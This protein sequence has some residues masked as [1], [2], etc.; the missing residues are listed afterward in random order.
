MSQTNFILIALVSCTLLFTAAHHFMLLSQKQIS[1]IAADDPQRK[2]SV[3]SFPDS[4]STKMIPIG[5]KLVQQKTSAF[6][7]EHHGTEY[8]GWTC[9]VSTFTSNTIVYDVGLGEDTSWDEGLIQKYNLQIFGFDPT[10]K[11]ALHVDQ[12]FPARTHFH[13]LKEGLSTRKET[14]TFTKPKNANHVSMRAG[15]VKGLGATIDVKVNT[16]ENWMKA[17]GHT[18]IDVLKI[19]I[20]GSEYDVLED[21]IQRDYFPFDQLLVE[22]HFRWD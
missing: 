17:N 22:W 20:E 11:S 13:Y 5:N 1:K 21:F 18:H 12:T 8:G 10:P 14:K 9:D 4:F 7:L 3:G 2:G 19:D 6:K 16:I 15:D